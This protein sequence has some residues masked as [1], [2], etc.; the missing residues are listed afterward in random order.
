M[1]CART[2]CNMAQVLLCTWVGMCARVCHAIVPRS[3]AAADAWG[4]DTLNPQPSPPPQEGEPSYTA[5]L[6]QG[7][8]NGDGTALLPLDAAVA[9][10]PASLGEFGIKHVEF[11]Q[12]QQQ[13]QQQQL[14]LEHGGGSG[15][16]ASSGGGGGGS[17]SS[18][19]AGARPSS[20][21]GSGDGDAGQPA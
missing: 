10:L 11:Q 3:K 18:P 15:G 4:S 14:K 8:A 5:L 12:Q 2:L 13:Q 7:A 1:H 20:P 6:Q 9:L 19:A 17:G 16:V 21:T